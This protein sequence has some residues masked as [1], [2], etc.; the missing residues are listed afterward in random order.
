MERP[1]GGCLRS[2]G[3]RIWIA[4]VLTGHVWG[5]FMLLMHE[6]E[7]GGR[8]ERQEVKNSCRLEAV[9]FSTMWENATRQFMFKA[10][11]H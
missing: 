6:D 9:G 4:E 11:M 1:L 7:L 3:Q 10:A 2:C 5:L 8:V